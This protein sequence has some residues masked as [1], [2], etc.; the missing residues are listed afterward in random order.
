MSR[1]VLDNSES[2]HIAEIADKFL[3]NHQPW[4]PLAAID[5]LRTEA[6]ELPVGVRK[7]LVE[8]RTREDAVIT[9][10]NLPVSPDLAPTPAGWRDAEREEAGR[11]E[12]ITLLLCASILGDPFSWANQ[13]DGRLVHDVCPS[14]GM[15]DSLTSASSE[16][17][18]T[19]HTEDVFHACRGDYVALMCLRNPDAV[20]TTVARVLPGML[21][22][23]VMDVLR[24][25]RF[26]FYPDDS[27]I[28]VPADGAAPAVALTDRPYEQGP[29]L[30]GPADDHYLRIDPDFTV[31]VPGDTEAE[32]ALRLCSEALAAATERLVLEP[33]E[34]AFLDNYR[35]IHGREVF[36]P[37]YDGKDR[38]LKRTSMVRDLRRSYVH[39]R[40]RSR[41]LA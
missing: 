20:G 25:S 11:L 35:V 32:E 30:F 27:H 39:E 37:R 3:R 9:L 4:R 8:A 36:T 14:K 1:Y 28:T 5:D 13:Q 16:T 10:A 34:A 18:L 40:S 21:P 2:S 33:G 24:Q 12:E 15:E 17:Q 31:A 26:R 6:E 38:W 23:G 7:F 22:E 19:L 41:V 29:V